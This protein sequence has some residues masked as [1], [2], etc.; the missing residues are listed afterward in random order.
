MS[1]LSLVSASR[2]SM[3]DLA[4]A[5]TTYYAIKL[6]EIELVKEAANS[7]RYE[8]LAKTTKAVAGVAARSFGRI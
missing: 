4:I 6:G 2:G 3:L 7:R 5:L 8:Q 1:K